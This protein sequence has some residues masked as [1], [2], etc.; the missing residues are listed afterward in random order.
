MNFDRPTC[1]Y[2]TAGN[3]E[4]NGLVLLLQ[5]NDIEAYAVDDVSGASLFAYGKLTQF[6]QPKVF[7]NRDDAEAAARLIHEFESR[8]A[9][10]RKA[11]SGAM[12]VAA[13]EDVP[14]VCDECG[15]TTMFPGGQDGTIQ[16]CPHCGK[17]RDVGATD[18]GDWSG[19][20][21]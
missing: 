19:E 15:E 9:S 18:D 13:T 5:N 21:E 14:G 7:V 2:T 12:P 1:V 10:R 16:R 4:A 11:A 3:I 20:E 17:Y 8:E 6:H